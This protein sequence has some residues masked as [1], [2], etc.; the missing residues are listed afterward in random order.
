MWRWTTPSCAGAV[1]L[2]VPARH[3]LHQAPALCRGA[4]RRRPGII[5]D[6]GYANDC[7]STGYPRPPKSW[8]TKAAKALKRAAQEKAIEEKAA[9]K[10]AAHKA[11]NKAAK[12]AAD[13]K[14]ANKTTGTKDEAGN[15]AKAD[16]KASKKAARCFLNEG[17]H[18][19]RA[20]T[21]PA[22]LR[23]QPH[24]RP[25]APE[26]PPHNELQPPLPP[27]RGAAGNRKLEARNCPPNR[28]HP[29]FADLSSNGL[30]RA[31]NFRGPATK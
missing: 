23:P 24:P 22:V 9:K 15:G 28:P 6:D 5:G 1:E 31:S 27:P 12:K 4:E 14:A 17:Q 7:D 26:V 19:H 10:A 8:V 20:H 25:A 21:G 29:T 13:A 30:V 2:P 18:S 16:T 3:A 11:A